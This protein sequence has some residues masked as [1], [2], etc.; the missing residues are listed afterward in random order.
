M[1]SSIRWIVISAA[2]LLL[3][4]SP[5]VNA[6]RNLEAVRSIIDAVNAK[7]ANKYAAVFAEDAVV[8]LYGG[9]VR[10]R[11][12]T[13][14]RENRAQHFR[15]F[16]Q[17][18]SEI[19]HLVEI[20]TIV[21][22]HDRVWLHA[23]DQQPAEIVEVFTFEG[24][25]IVKVEVIQPDDLLSRAAQRVHSGPA[26]DVQVL[27]V[28][29]H[30][31]VKSLMAASYFN[32]LA[33]DRGLRAWAFSRGFAPDSD[34]VPASIASALERDRFNVTQFHPEKVTATDVEKA[35]HVVTIGADLPIAIHD[36][37]PNLHQWN[38]VPA[39]S[40]DYP[41]ARDALLEHIEKL[42]AEISTGETR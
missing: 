17:A 19:Q 33:A 39:A 41:A 11:G 37:G 4:A 26:P 12:R 42:I 20:G 5:V 35:Q 6:S 3:A 38:D 30:G 14:L 13:Q 22:M 36:D 10:V 27:F 1:R 28:C 24:G 29:E 15:R 21:V 9:P 7:D 23:T 25:L 32:R 40:V 31:N 18:R 34:T 16:P 8:Q 2:T